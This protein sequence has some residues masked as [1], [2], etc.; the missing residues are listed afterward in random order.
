MKKK[1]LA[2]V[3]TS[4]L[5][6]GGLTGCGQRETASS[7]ENTYTQDLMEQSSNIVGYPEVTNFFEKEFSN[8][9]FL[10][11][12][13]NLEIVFFQLFCFYQYFNYIIKNE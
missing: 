13:K 12:L 10:E 8:H 3:M 9:F 2:V 5:L 4:V 11:I 6:V 7:K 1:I